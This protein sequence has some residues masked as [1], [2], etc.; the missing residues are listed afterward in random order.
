MKK[1][2]HILKRKSTQR[3]NKLATKKLGYNTKSNQRLK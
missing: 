1:Y 3:D 2:L